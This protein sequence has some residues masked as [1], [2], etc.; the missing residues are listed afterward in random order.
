MTSHVRVSS[1]TKNLELTLDG[2]LVKKEAL[3]VL[4]KIREND[5]LVIVP[6]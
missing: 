6:N 5:E 2:F 4:K 1:N 3:G